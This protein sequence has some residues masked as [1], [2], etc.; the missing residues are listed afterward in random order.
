M[1]D[2]AAAST[3]KNTRHVERC[4]EEVVFIKLAEAITQCHRTCAF[5][6]SDSSRTERCHSPTYHKLSVL[7][8]PRPHGM[9]VQLC[10]F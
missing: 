4:L 2:Q 7:A 10:A 8:D 1:R 3:M 6:I 5:A 9:C